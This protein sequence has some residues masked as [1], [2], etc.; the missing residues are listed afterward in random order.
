LK[1]ESDFRLNLNPLDFLVG[2]QW[3]GADF[4]WIRIRKFVEQCNA[5][6]FCII[7]PYIHVHAPT[8]TIFF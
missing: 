1:E 2:L 7:P 4:Y 8:L 6:A 5:D 3:A